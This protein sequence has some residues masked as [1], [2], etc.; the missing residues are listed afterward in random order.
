MDY[1]FLIGVDF[2]I[3]STSMV[4]YNIEENTFKFF[5]FPTARTRAH[6]DISRI[7]KLN[8]FVKKF[9]KNQE[10][11]FSAIK[12]IS[13]A[14]NLTVQILTEILEVTKGERTAVAIEGY[15]FGSTGNNLIDLVEF[16]TVFR[17]GVAEKITKDLYVFAPSTVKK[18]FTSSGNA[19]KIKM[20]DVFINLDDIRLEKLQEV[21]LEYSINKKTKEYKASIPKPFDD[22][23][24]SFA[25]LKTLESY[26]NG[27]LDVGAK[28]KRIKKE[29]KKDVSGVDIDLKKD[30]IKKSIKK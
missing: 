18:L 3:I 10:Y 26:L 13:L 19:N 11:S 6:D 22:I 9:E 14:Q 29:V 16:Q 24:D 5:N 12:N 23:V 21:T 4:I 17:L 20:V 28:S 2:S 7:V 25:V 27:T 1:K 15:S 30:K 8:T